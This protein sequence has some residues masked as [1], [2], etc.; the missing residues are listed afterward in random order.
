LDK[1]SPAIKDEVAR[2]YA[3]SV[4]HLDHAVGRIVAALEQAGKRNDT[5]LIF[6]SDNGGSKVANHDQP[7]PPDSYP[8][9]K[10][11]GNNDPWRGQKGELYEGGI[12]TPGLISWPGRLK[13]GQFRAAMQIVDWMP[14]LCA[15]A[16]YRPERDLK[17]DG[18]NV[19]PQI[20]G[21]AKP[22][23]RVLYW[24]T[25]QA[26][27]VRE[28]DWKL[29]VQSGRAGKQSV[30]QPK[31]ELFNLA[32]DPRETTELSAQQPEQ[33]AK[34]KEKLAIVSRADGDAQVRD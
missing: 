28:G 5:I 19:W 33:V 9:G 17:W 23:A 6:T 15:I 4:M 20:T 27:A 12:R 34:L 26:S 24:T 22:V 11:P 2:H 30:K 21:E 29:I 13:P 16:G 32:K 31:V 14:T 3:A 18:T 1:V 8:Q 10:L 7:Y 25:P